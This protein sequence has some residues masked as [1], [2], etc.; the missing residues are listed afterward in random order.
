[1]DFEKHPLLDWLVETRRDFHM[2]PEISNQEHRTIGRIKE[3]LTALGIDLQ[4]LDNVPTGAAGLIKGANNGPVLAVRADIDA[5]PMEELN[6]VPYK[7]K[8]SGVMHSC[9][10]DG[11][12]TVM[13]GLAKNLV[14]SGLA[15]QINGQLKF[16]FQPAEERGSGARQMINGG[17]LDNPRPDRIIACHMHMELPVGQVG[18]YKEISHASADLFTLNIQGKGVHGAAPHNGIDPV[19]AGAHFVAA[20]QSIVNR[21]IDPTDSA[22]VTVG[23]FQAGSAP[24]IIPD[25]AYL[26]GTTRAFKME[27]RDLVE[28]R[29]RELAEG[30]EKMYRVEVKFEVEEGVPVAQM[31][32]EVTD[33]L[34]EAA[35]KVV[36]EENVHWMEPR[37]GAEDF[38]LY[39]QIIPNTFMRLGCGNEARGLVHPGHSPYYDFD[40]TALA[41]GVEIFTEAVR[42]YLT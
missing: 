23:Q 22:V 39:S 15:A 19:V 38:A 17:V 29:L 41:V 24:N 31:T 30:L 40:E 32:R 14:E 20:A 13:L 6:D 8:N 42:S 36:G 35:I 5:L 26:T 10:H 3:T 18:F 33:Y 11:H 12:A 2:N 34:R 25:S 1:M 28:K 16:L 4:E 9:G 37:M 21:N 7:S 27:T